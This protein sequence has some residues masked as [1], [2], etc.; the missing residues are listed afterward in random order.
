MLLY[1]R[2]I[3]GPSSEIFGCLRKSSETFVFPS[4]Q[5]GKIFGKWSEIFRKSSKT[6]SL[7]GSFKTEYYMSACGYEFYVLV[8]NLTSHS[9][10]ALTREI[11]SSTLEDKIHIHPQACDILYMSYRLSLSV[12]RKLLVFIKYLRQY[13]HPH[14]SIGVFR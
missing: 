9:F 4:E 12:M 10:A 13:A 8:F 11:S 14:W 5:F 7:V 3:I 6:S 1:D 2:N